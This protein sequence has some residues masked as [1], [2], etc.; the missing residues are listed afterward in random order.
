MKK[1]TYIRTIELRKRMS[2]RMSKT[3]NHFYGKKHSDETKRKIGEINS[4]KRLGKINT[5]ET[6]KKMSEAKKG[7][8]RTPNTSEHNKN[9]SDGLKG[10]K[11]YRWIKDR[12]KLAKRQERNDTAYKEWRRQVWLR[13]SFKCK[14]ANPDCKGRIEAHH[15]LGWTAHPELRY[16][17]NNGITLCHVHHPKKREDEAKLSPYFQKL[18]AEMK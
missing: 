16:Q 17:V 1:G 13:D 18:V 5:L 9:I 12:T 14:I 15:I 3:G 10:E 11:S 8:R 2:L 4:I 7:K 6:L